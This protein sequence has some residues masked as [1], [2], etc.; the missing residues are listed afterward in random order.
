MISDG[1]VT[2][3]EVTRCLSSIAPGVP[4]NASVTGYNVVGYGKTITAYGYIQELGKAVLLCIVDPLFI[5]P[6]ICPSHLLSLYC[7]IS[8]LFIAPSLA[9]LLLHL[10]PLYCSISCLFIAPSLAS[11]LLHL[12]PLY[13]SISCLFI[14]PFLVSLLLHLLSLYC[15]ISCLFIAPSL[16]SLL[17]HLLSL[18]CSISC[19]F[20]A[21][22]LASLLLH[23]LSLYCSISCLFIAPSLASLLLHLLSLYCSI[24]PLPLFIFPSSF[25]IHVSPYFNRYLHPFSGAFHILKALVCH[26]LLQLPCFVFAYHSSQWPAQCQ[27]HAHKW[28]HHSC[29][30]ESSVSS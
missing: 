20:I 14:A 21:P 3:N 10:L 15:S 22:S 2:F 13:C 27:D 23:L 8:C 30:L 24:S 16:A 18:Y 26:V 12:L 29:Q 25:R 1:K 5:H 7:S 28:K 11:L 6:F 17:L 19:L 9:S 4:Y